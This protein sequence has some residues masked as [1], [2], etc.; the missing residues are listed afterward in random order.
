MMMM[1]LMMMM[2]VVPQSQH[3]LW[4]DQPEIQ[5]SQH[6]HPQRGLG[7]LLDRPDPAVFFSDGAKLNFTPNLASGVL[8]DLLLL[9]LIIVLEPRSACTVKTVRGVTV[10]P[11]FAC[12]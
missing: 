10:L 3:N 6:V 12:M 4:D 11:L 8:E 9:F 5:E 7:D 1:M 2:A